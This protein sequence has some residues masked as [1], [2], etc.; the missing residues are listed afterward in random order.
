MM[1]TQGNSRRPVRIDVSLQATLTTSDNHVMTVRVRDLSAGGCRVD[2]PVGEELLV[3]EDI[4]LVMD[5]DERLPG[6]IRW[7]LGNEA[8]V[9]FLLPP[10]P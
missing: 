10:E 8:G 3:G 4:N 1:S 7:A 2:L 9:I 6:Q 5:G